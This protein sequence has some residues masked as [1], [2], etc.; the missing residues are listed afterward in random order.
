M[1]VPLW[2]AETLKAGVKPGTEGWDAVVTELYQAGNHPGMNAFDLMDLAEIIDSV[3][4]P[5]NT[6][7]ANH[8]V[9]RQV[10]ARDWPTIAQQLE[11]PLPNRTGFLGISGHTV[12]QFL[13]RTKMSEAFDP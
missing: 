7:W 2:C 8:S 10:L 3:I 1:R 4:W 6:L 13:G 9:A 11:P 12:D 5:G